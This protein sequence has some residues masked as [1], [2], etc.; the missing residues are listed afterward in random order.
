MLIT[1]RRACIIMIIF[2]LRVS[3]L[4]FLLSILLLTIGCGQKEPWNEEDPREAYQQFLRALE[5]E[6]MHIVWEMLSDEVR[7]QLTEESKRVE[8]ISG[9][10]LTPKPI[11]LLSVGRIIYRHEIKSTTL[12]ETRTTEGDVYLLVERREGT[13]TEVHLFRQREHW[14]VDLQSP[15]TDR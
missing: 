8:M 15:V 7:Q 12:I 5:R 3:P 6:D 10:M 13:K 1:D 2:K 14:V 11:E 4:I 9:G